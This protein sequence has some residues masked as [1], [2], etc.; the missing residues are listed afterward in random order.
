MGK[1]NPPV[2]IKLYSNSSYVTCLTLYEL[3]QKVTNKIHVSDTTDDT[4]FI[5]MI[6]VDSS[7]INYCD[8]AKTNGEI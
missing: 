6:G 2:L 1:K 3:F 8:F 4:A 5:N 7:S